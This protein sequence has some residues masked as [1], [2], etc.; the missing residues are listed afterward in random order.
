[1]Q[2]NHAANRHQELVA[3]NEGVPLAAQHTEIYAHD[4]WGVHRAGSY[5]HWDIFQH[6]HHCCG[7]ANA[8]D[9]CLFFTKVTAQPWECI[10]D[11][12]SYARYLCSA[13]NI[14]VMDVLPL[15][16]LELAAPVWFCN[17]EG[18]ILVFWDSPIPHGSK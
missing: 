17:S 5:V 9:R 16:C 18:H 14:C 12:T 7:S 6:T 3:K 13:V 8:H 1:M 4:G 11:S 2:I 10:Q 15:R